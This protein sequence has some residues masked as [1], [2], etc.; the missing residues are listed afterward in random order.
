[1]PPTSSAESTA[2]TPT[3]RNATEAEANAV[4]ARAARL[5]DESSI[6]SVRDLLPTA[7][8]EDFQRRRAAGLTHGCAIT[9]AVSQL[10]EDARVG[11]LTVEDTTS[12]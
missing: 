3:R 1:M 9:A 2:T 7:Y 5:N 10:Q 11:A 4:L 8:V 12:K 6:D